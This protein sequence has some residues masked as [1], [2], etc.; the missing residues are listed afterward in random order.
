MIVSFLLGSY[1]CYYVSMKVQKTESEGLLLIDTEKHIDER[2]VFIENYNKKLYEAIGIID[3][4]VQDNISISHRGVLRGLHFQMEPFAQ[5]KLVRVIS[6]RV[7]DVV[8]DLRHTSQT[9]GKYYM[10]ELSSENNKQLYIPEGFAH[11]FI[12]LEDNTVFVYKTN[13]YWNKESERTL[14]WNDKIL[15]ITWPNIEKIISQKDGLG[16]PF[17]EL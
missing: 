13:Q 12:A 1:T 17:S 6:G 4:F 2:G 7:I 10:F 11:G 3:T 9:Y 5:S 14:L 16:I 8:V 15:N